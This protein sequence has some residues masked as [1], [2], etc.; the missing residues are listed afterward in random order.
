[1]S[2]QMSRKVGTRIVLFILLATILVTFGIQVQEEQ[3]KEKT[4]HLIFVPKT[5][6]SANDFWTAL[7]K[8]AELGAEE[9]GAEI[10]VVG[11][12]SEDDVETQIK[13]IEESIQ[14]NPEAILVAPADYSLL[15]DVLQKVKDAGI[16]LIYIDST[17]ENDIADCE[18]STDNYK[19]G[20]ELGKYAKTLIDEDIKIGIMGHVKGTSTEIERE[21]GIRDGLENYKANIVDILY[22][23]SSYEKA[24]SQ[25]K[26]MLMKNPEIR[27]LIGTNEYA[28]VG[29]A[30]AIKDMGMEKKSKMVGFDNSV[31]EIQL[32]EE[33]VFDGIIIQKPF[34]MGYMGVEQAIALLEGKTV[35]KTLDS[36]CKL[37]TRDNMYEEEN[38]RL[39]Y[40]FSGQ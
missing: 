35:E 5:I 10:E 24:Y 7:I 4:Y 6:D 3:E 29:T 18:V 9:F 19:A 33:G 14:K 15:H 20:K 11:G 40:P 1:M 13:T 37:I 22:C 27:L 39:L 26:T 36:G 38:Q 25:T 30:R 28:T 23:D 34:N 31:E 2:R 12:R 17:T 21:N 8:G 32:L 16:T